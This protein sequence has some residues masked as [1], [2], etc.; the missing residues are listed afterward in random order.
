MP[1]VKVWLLSS[2]EREA[3]QRTDIRHPVHVRA[4]GVA[5]EFVNIETWAAALLVDGVA[6]RKSKLTGGPNGLDSVLVVAP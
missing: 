3:N 4:L 5:L 1:E 2:D 6:V